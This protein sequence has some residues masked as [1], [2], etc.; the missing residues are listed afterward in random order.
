MGNQ[1]GGAYV[2]CCGQLQGIG[3]FQ[4]GDINHQFRLD[5][6]QYRLYVPLL[7]ND[8]VKVNL[9]QENYQAAILNSSAAINILIG[10]NTEGNF[11]PMLLPLRAEAYQKSG[12]L[13]LALDDYKQLYRMGNAAALDSMK[14]IFDQCNVK[15]KTFEAFTTILKP[16][17]L[18]KKANNLTMAPDITATDLN[19]KTVRLSDMKGKLVVINI[20]GIGCGPCIAEMPELNKLVKQFPDREK[21]VFLGLTGDKTQSL[22]KFFKSHTYDYKVLNNVTNLSEKF[23]TNSL[24]VHIV[25]GKEGEIISRSIGARVDIK[26]YLQGL[27]IS[28]L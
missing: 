24:P 15:Q 17:N 25:V 28:N 26:E 14:K 6:S 7:L 18:S 4:T 3:Q 5:N 2:E 13:N 1:R 9:L 10:S 11:L 21:I 19:G 20:W 23:N 16:E 22:M 8:L 12:N 27:I